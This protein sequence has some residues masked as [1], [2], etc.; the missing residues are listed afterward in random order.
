MA[1]KKQYDFTEQEL[2]SMKNNGSNATKR[3]REEQE[4]EDDN[5][6]DYD[7]W[8][9]LKLLPQSKKQKVSKP[10]IEKVVSALYLQ[11]QQNAN[12]TQQEPSDTQSALGILV[13]AASVEAEYAPLV[14]SDLLEFA[15]DHRKTKAAH[16]L[17]SKANLSELEMI[18]GYFSQFQEGMTDNS[19]DP[20]DT[21][22]TMMAQNESYMKILNELRK[23]M[24][25]MLYHCPF[26]KC[27][28]MIKSIVTLCMQEKFASLLSED[29]K[30]CF[31]GYAYPGGRVATLYTTD[32]LKKILR[33]LLVSFDLIA[34]DSATP[35][36]KTYGGAESPHSQYMH[37]LVSDCYRLCLHSHR[38]KSKQSE[39][40][41]DEQVRYQFDHYY[42]CNVLGK[43]N[44]GRVFGIDDS[45]PIFMEVCT[46]SLE[47]WYV[48][49]MSSGWF[50]SKDV[51]STLVGTTGYS[52][53]VERIG[54][55]EE[56]AIGSVP[57]SKEDKQPQFKHYLIALYFEL[58]KGMPSNPIMEKCDRQCIKACMYIE[59]S[60]YA[61]LVDMAKTERIP[62]EDMNSILWNWWLRVAK[63]KH[64]SLEEKNKYLRYASIEAGLGFGVTDIVKAI[65]SVRD[66][67]NPV[68]R[69]RLSYWNAVCHLIGSAP[70]QVLLDAASKSKDAQSLL[71]VDS[72]SKCIAGLSIIHKSKKEYKQV[73]ATLAFLKKDA[74]LLKAIVQM[75][76]PQ[77]KLF[78]HQNSVVEHVVH[79][80]VDLMN[81]RKQK[82]VPVLE[83]SLA[84]TL[85]FKIRKIFAIVFWLCDKDQ[86]NE[87]VESIKQLVFSKSYMEKFGGVVA[88][89]IVDIAKSV[90]SAASTKEKTIEH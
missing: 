47:K 72:V 16:Q 85:R 65:N 1:Y 39:R 34:I 5:V 9:D 83:G 4:H 25:E 12:L 59:I 48:F 33:D 41:F 43:I 44:A 8:Q 64:H 37:Q 86:R 90:A 54:A 79:S 89:A 36:D 88:Q 51:Q 52:F 80:F 40:A 63:D 18:H 73:R 27:K 26:D 81:P 76:P 61:K 62:K 49:L 69:Q 74:Q 24:S 66:A 15:K 58:T 77:E 67:N 75:T 21:Y 50:H 7:D 32:P 70:R 55:A 11:V 82:R 20:D 68:T 28:E 6:S 10:L 57:L 84:S 30:H 13:A 23:H 71:F 78:P 45:H 22:R 29:Q 46:S 35:R 14:L 53:I 31:I 60:N 17:M 56:K 19:G 38:I 2:I 87:L 3:P 42:P